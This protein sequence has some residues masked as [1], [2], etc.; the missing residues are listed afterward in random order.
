MF[1]ETIKKYKLSKTELKHYTVTILSDMQ[2]E[3]NIDI[4]N[5]CIYSNIKCMF[6][7]EGVEMP[8]LVFWN[9]KF[10]NGFPASIIYNYA[11]I[12]MLSGFS[13]HILSI[14][15]KQRS[16]KEK[17]KYKYNN[18]FFDVLNNKRYDF[19]NKEI[20]EILLL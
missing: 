1:I 7:S 8:Q 14:F 5:Q 4:K 17:S 13:E 15:N 10:Y 16:L 11:N 12:L 2:V 6:N 18:I 9:L 19:V 20:L 3:D